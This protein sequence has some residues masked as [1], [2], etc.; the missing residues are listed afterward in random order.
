[1]YKCQICNCE[2]SDEHEFIN[3]KCQPQRPC[4]KTNNII[5]SS[6]NIRF[7]VENL[8]ASVYNIKMSAE[9]LEDQEILEIQEEMEN[10][11][12]GLISL[13]DRKYIWK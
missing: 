1:M 7:N 3:H 12:R 5:N 13:L 8:Q 4:K 11:N 9:T 6:A 2:F 10:L